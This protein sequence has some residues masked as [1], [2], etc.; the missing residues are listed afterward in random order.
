MV[1]EWINTG[2]R[3]KKMWII[4]R[5]KNERKYWAAAFVIISLKLL[6]SK[7]F[8][9]RRPFCLYCTCA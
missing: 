1:N 6:F 3:L 7:V 9:M 4:I 8:F 5:E 2:D